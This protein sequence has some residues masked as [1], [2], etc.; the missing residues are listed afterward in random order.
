MRLTWKRVKCILTLVPD[1]VQ[2]PPQ[3][4]HSDLQGGHA[5]AGLAWAQMTPMTHTHTQWPG[6][7]KT[8]MVQ[9]VGK[10]VTQQRV[11]AVAAQPGYQPAITTSAPTSIKDNM[12]A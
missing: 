9:Q 12:S 1:A 11:Q 4:E 10:E 7:W 3:L 5:E 6:I 2:Q 8:E